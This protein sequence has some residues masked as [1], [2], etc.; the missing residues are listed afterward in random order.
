MIELKIGVFSPV[1]ELGED[2][3][4][5][6]FYGDMV[7]SPILDKPNLDLQGYHY[8]RHGDNPVHYEPK[9]T[10]LLKKYLPF[11]NRYHRI[12]VNNVLKE[13]F[14]SCD[15]IVIEYT[16]IKY[17]TV[18][19]CKALQGH[20]VLFDDVD[21]AYNED[22][23][24]TEFK[25]LLNKEGIDSST[26][27]TINNLDLNFWLLNRVAASSNVE[28][29]GTDDFKKLYSDNHISKQYYKTKSKNFIACLGQPNTH[30]YRID[31]LNFCIRNNIDNNYISI[32]RAPL[33]SPLKGLEPYKDLIDKYYIEEYDK[34]YFYMLNKWKTTVYMNSYFTVVPETAYGGKK[35]CTL[36]YLTTEKTYTPMI[37]GHPFMSFDPKGNPDYLVGLGFELFDEIHDPYNN[38]FDSYCL[39]VLDF[40][41][42][43]FTDQTLDKCIHN[44]NRLYDKY[45]ILE[46][47]ENFLQKFLT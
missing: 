31:F 24:L 39:S 47:W 28:Y 4:S 38:D 3:T 1:S 14:N 8:N 20:C 22:V 6:K 16:Q 5:A 30:Q 17:L 18:E 25:D 32:G 35:D 41:K 21:E 37:Y 29:L 10:F 46:V 26:F 27:K 7:V 42:D 36:E 2:K 44:S 11:L 23:L 15:I 34:E 45:L 43:V 9:T 12:S 19:H 13:H 33:S 40:N